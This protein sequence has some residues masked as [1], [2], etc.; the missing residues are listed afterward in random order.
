MKYSRLVLS[1][2]VI[3]LLLLTIACGSKEPV[4]ETLAGEMNL[5]AADI[6]PDWSLLEDQSLDEMPDS[7]LPHVRDASMRMFG[8]EGIT[9]MVISCVF[10]TKTVA[11]AEREMATGDVTSSFAEGLQEQ[12]PEVT[13]ETLE[14]P[15]IGDEAVMTGGSY[16]ELGLNIYMLTFR[17]ANVIVMFAV[18]GPEEFA[19]EEAVAGYAQKLEAKTH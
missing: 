6:G 10:S 16:S 18:I 15:S 17:K 13:L 2:T 8:A 1:L 3:C 7:D 12:V 4:I 14:P 9:G 5:S 19:T 11:S